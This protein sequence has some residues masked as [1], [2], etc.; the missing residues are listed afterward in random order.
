M[1]WIF[2]EDTL[3]YLPTRRCLPASKHLLQKTKEK[4]VQCFIHYY[5]HNSF[6]T[7]VKKLKLGKQTAEALYLFTILNKTTHLLI[8]VK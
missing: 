2:V 4:N 6:S 7:N 8:Q 1:E 3:M 5:Q